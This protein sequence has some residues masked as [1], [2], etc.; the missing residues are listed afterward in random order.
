MCVCMG[1]GV[2][3]WVGGWVGGCCICGVRPCPREWLMKL[4]Q[5][6]FDVVVRTPNMIFKVNPDLADIVF[7]STDSDAQDT[8]ET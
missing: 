3:G 6:L 2:G 4:D 8:L 5:S 7:F 1:V